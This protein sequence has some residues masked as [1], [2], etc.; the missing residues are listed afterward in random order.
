MAE[1]M[2]A[3]ATR[4]GGGWGSARAQSPH[5]EKLDAPAQALTLRLCPD[6]VIDEVEIA[7]LGERL[8]P[9]DLGPL[10]DLLLFD[11][12][13]TYRASWRSGELRRRLLRR[14]A[15]ACRMRCAT[16]FEEAREEWI[17][18]QAAHRIAQESHRNAQELAQASHER[19]L[20][21]RG[22]AAGPERGAEDG[23]CA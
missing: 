14:V 12:R 18:A 9:L 20:L 10:V 17:E 16:E 5:L 7:Q 22:G 23:M 4:A 21:D 6:R 13:R 11:M 3:G 15:D 8:Q 1:F 19:R 2:R